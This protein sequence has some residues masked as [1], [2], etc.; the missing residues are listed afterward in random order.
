MRLPFE[1]AG[2]MG[3]STV[4]APRSRRRAGFSPE[5]RRFA[6]SEFSNGESLRPVSAKIYEKFKLHVAIST[7]SSWRRAAGILPKQKGGGSR[8][9]S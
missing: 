4:D 5:I 6:L 3:L 1:L 7:L 9:K 8:A 2:L